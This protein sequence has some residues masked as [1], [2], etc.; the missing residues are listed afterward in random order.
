MY[1]IKN[2][3]ITRDE[4]RYPVIFRQDDARQLGKSLASRNSVEL[5]GMKRV[6]ISNFLRFFLYHDDI[7][8]T[9]IH[10]SDR[11]LFIP[12]DLNDLI[13]I[14]MVPFWTLT[15]KR[16]VDLVNRNKDLESFRESVNSHFMRSIQLQDQFYILD[17]IRETITEIANKGF[18][19]TLFFLRFD[20][21]NKTAKPE[22]LSNLKGL[23]EATAHR[24]CYV[25]T[26]YRELHDLIPHVFS[27]TAIFTFYQQQYLKPGNIEDSR[28][29]SDTIKQ[30]CHITLPKDVENEILL[31]SGG[32]VQY[33]HLSLI[34]LKELLD[35]NGTLSNNWFDHLA[36][37]ERLAL[38]SEE[39]FSTLNDLEKE[40]I[41]KS[42]D[43]CTNYSYDEMDQAR[44]LWN[45]GYINQKHCIFSTLFHHYMMQKEVYNKK[46][47]QSENLTKKEQLLFDVLKQHENQ[48]CEREEIVRAVWPECNE[49]GVSDW[50]VDRLVARLRSKLKKIESV[51][52]IQTVK[53]RG[54]MLQPRS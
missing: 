9:Y 14:E 33:I 16:I 54:F 27:K 26:T 46:A 15:L 22:L 35:K 21:L 47:K 42:G 13:E 40:T 48:I 41:I 6:G 24:L 1:N 52:A 37:E 51:Y 8:R 36:Q 18:Y 45:A 3:K 43:K 32:H 50:A 31:A 12:V 23:I 2:M 20:R 30:K 7:V 49:L 39:L 34:V 10:P 19:P 44:Y 38:Q 4:Q 5:I 11:H 25:F 28:I 17:A 53:T 29:I